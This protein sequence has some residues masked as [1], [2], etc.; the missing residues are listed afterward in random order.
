MAVNYNFHWADFMMT[1]GGNMVLLLIIA[2]ILL[3]D[4][5]VSSFPT[6]NVKNMIQEMIPSTGSSGSS[7]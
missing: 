1:F 7:K 5:G 6:K 3:S 2:F 4:T